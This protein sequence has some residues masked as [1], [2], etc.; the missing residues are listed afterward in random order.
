MPSQIVKFLRDE[1]KD[2]KG[3]T[4]YEMQTLPDY[5]LERTHDVIQWMFPT[6]L[7]SKHDPNAPVLTEEDIAV[8]K[9]DLMVQASIQTSLTRMIWFFEKNDYWITQR[10]HNFLR[11][12]RILRCLWLVGLKHDYVCLQK[13]LDDIYTDY[14]DIIGEETFLFWKSANNDEFMK[15]EHKTTEFIGPCLPASNEDSYEDFGYV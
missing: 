12:T 15:G 11:I 7:P 13:A 5:K 14:P 3:R 10:N 2:Y 8:M 6:D 9:N 1:G 4:L